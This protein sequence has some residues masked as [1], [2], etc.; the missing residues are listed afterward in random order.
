MTF[1]VNDCLTAAL[2]V[3]L[4]ADMMSGS[5]V[6]GFVCIVKIKTFDK[7]RHSIPA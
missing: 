5:G 6:Q 3:T 2:A 4:T 7:K 1:P